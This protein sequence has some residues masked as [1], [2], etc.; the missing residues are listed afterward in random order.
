MRMRGRP[1]HHRL[2]RVEVLFVSGYGA[3]RNLGGF[4]N[5][6]MAMMIAFVCAASVGIE[7][8]ARSPASKQC[9]LSKAEKKKAIGLVKTMYPQVEDLAKE[10]T[11]TCNLD[12]TFKRVQF[13]P[14]TIVSKKSGVTFTLRTQVSVSPDDVDH[15]AEPARKFDFEAAGAH[16]AKLPVAKVLFDGGAIQCDARHQYQNIDFFCGQNSPGQG[17]TSRYGAKFFRV[18]ENRKHELELGTLIGPLSLVE[19]LDDVRWLK[20]SQDPEVAAFVKKYPEPTVELGFRGEVKIMTPDTDDRG[21][22]IANERLYYRDGKARVSKRG[23]IKS[24]GKPI[25]PKK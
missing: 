4:M 2:H 1:C 14:V 15:I 20:A 16:I 6:I 3:A 24:A 10:D 7:A 23:P 9:T 13:E 21:V 5:R 11:C 8:E 18:F 22:S 25:E 12:C 17:M 19:K